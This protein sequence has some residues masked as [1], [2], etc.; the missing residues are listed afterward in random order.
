MSEENQGQSAPIQEVA[1]QTQEGQ[2]QLSQDTSAQATPTTPQEQKIESKRLQKLKLKVYGE[3]MDEDLPD[4]LK[5][6]ESPE[7]VEYLT[8]QFQMAKAAQRA[9]QENSSYKNQVQ[10][11]FN[12]FKADTRAALEQ[13]GIDP[14]QFAAA[15]IE[16]EIKKSQ[17][18]PEQRRAEDAEA[19][20]KK[21]ED[22]RKK[23][24]DELGKKEQE[25]M[26][27]LEY[28]KINTQFERALEKS[29]LPKEAYIVKK[30]AEYMLIASKQDVELS[31]EEVLPLVEQEIKSDIQALIRALGEDK[32]EEFVG[33]DVFNKIRKKN[34]AKSKNTPA[35]AIAQIRDTGQTSKGKDSATPEKKS[36]KDFFGI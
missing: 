10:Q 3:E 30:M 7:A 6:D 11:F 15:V 14:K 28:D 36:L 29:S 2:E 16:D 31:A 4:F 25:R 27:Q 35:T 34:I 8:K 1:P 5:V 20:L 26:Q 21:F 17:M 12:G 13:M 9:M 24:K 19:K 18:S 32:V 22:E 33:K 23:E